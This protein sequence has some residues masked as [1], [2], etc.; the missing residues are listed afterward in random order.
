LVSP[1]CRRAGRIHLPASTSDQQ[2]GVIGT[3]NALT[4]VFGL[5][6]NVGIAGQTTNPNSFAGLFIGNVAV[7]GAL[8]ANV[9]NGVVAF[10]DGTQRVLHCMESPEH[11]FED[12]GTAKLKNGRAMVKL[13]GD[14]A[15]II[16]RAGYHV[17]AQS[18]ERQQAGVSV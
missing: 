12:F 9:K 6:N 3:S 10:P 1:G 2:T 5:S 13:D 16:K 14:F 17:R 11:W 4:G 15:K 18:Q 8:T 7:N